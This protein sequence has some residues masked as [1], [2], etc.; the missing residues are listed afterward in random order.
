MS[1]MQGAFERAAAINA[2]ANWLATEPKP[3]SPVIPAICKR[4]GL[5]PAEACKAAKEA[6][7]RRARAI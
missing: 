6:A 7:L 3:P 2:A 5:S 4:F 1:T